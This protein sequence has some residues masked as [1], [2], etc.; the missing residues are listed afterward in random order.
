MA[1]RSVPL[2]GTVDRVVGVGPGAL[3]LLCHLGMADS[4][5][6]AELPE[7]DDPAWTPPYNLANPQFRELPTAGP[8]HGGDAEAILRQ[9][10]DLIVAGTPTAD[11]ADQLQSRTDVP[12][13]WIDQ[14][15][16]GEGREALYDAWRTVGRAVGN[17]ERAE[18]LVEF[19]ESVREDLATRTDGAGTP[20]SS[21]VGAVSHRGGKGLTST[22][23]PFPPLS[24]LGTASVADG[25]RD[26]EETESGSGTVKRTVSGEKLL[27]W[28][29][30]TIFLNRWNLPI[31]REETNGSGFS[32]LSAVQRGDVYGVHPHYFYDYNP[33]TMLANTYFMGTVLYPEAFADVEP[34]S[35]ADRIYDEFLG[36]E[37]Y[38]EVEAAFGP[39]GS[40]DLPG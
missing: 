17:P 39:Y 40:I 13:I 28:D 20:P 2:P 24:M 12:T 34:A 29:P 3:R 8:Q 31:V 21:Y 18:E 32:E 5:V 25:I 33:S 36:T 6:A 4:V 27:E 14:G 35:A 38:S 9:E 30:E 7:H 19:V 1:G 11:V 16:F 22:E 26:G 15:D 37:L 10:P 23:I